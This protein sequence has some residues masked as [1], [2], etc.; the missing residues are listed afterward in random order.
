MDKTSESEREGKK[1]GVFGGSAFAPVGVI[2][3]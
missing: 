1:Q 2:I 3:V